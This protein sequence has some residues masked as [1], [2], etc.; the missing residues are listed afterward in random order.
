MDAQL[1][2]IAGFAFMVPSSLELPQNFLPFLTSERGDEQLLSSITIGDIEVSGMKL[3]HHGL[4]IDDTKDLFIYKVD[5]GG[6]YA[7]LT[8]NDSDVCYQLYA[9]PT[10][11]KVVLSQN[12]IDEDCPRSVI[13][14]LMMLVFIYSS[15]YFKTILLHASC[16]KCGEEAVAFI[17]QS[18]AGKSTHSRLWLRYIPN[19]TLLNDDQPAI[20]IQDNNKVIV[21][22]TPWSGKTPCYI[23][24]N[25]LL[26]GIV[27]MKQ[28]PINNITPLTPV[29]LFQELLS[30]SSMI[31]ADPTTFKQITSTLALLVSQVP[32]F[33]LENRPEKEA[34]LITYTNTIQC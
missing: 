33:I 12:T 20:R 19:T 3:C 6:Y 21:Y 26:K 34:A 31:K 2:K 4:I 27:R 13:D 24:D 8:M 7:K 10:W 25:G 28:A 1:L 15:A 29:S 16:V 23:N 32:G 18:G 5:G 11:D 22:G 14:I 17:G 30:S 9:S